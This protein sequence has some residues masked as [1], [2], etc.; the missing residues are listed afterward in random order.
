MPGM[1]G[2]ELASRLGVSRPEMKVVYMSGYTDRVMSENS[3][4]DQSVTFLQKPFTPDQLTALV[5]RVL[6]TE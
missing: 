2:R 5:Q 3:V 6:G 1:N 4:L